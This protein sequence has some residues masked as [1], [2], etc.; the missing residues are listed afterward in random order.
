MVRKLSQLLSC[1][2]FP[3]LLWA[4]A[5]EPGG[6]EREALEELSESESE[7]ILAELTTSLPNYFPI[8][9][10]AG[11]AASYSPSGSI[12][13]RTAFHTSHGSNGRHCGHCHGP[14]SG[15]SVNPAEIQVAF[16]LT[17]GT[18]P[19]FNPLDANNPNADLSTFAKRA[20]GYSM[21]LKG[22]FRRGGVVR[23][24]AEYEI[25]AADDP[26]GFGS[27]ERFSV[28]RR[29]MPTSNLHLIN[30]IGW[31]DRTT[32]PGDTYAG[33]LAQARGNI[34]GGQQGQAPD[35]AIVQEIVDWELTI[36]HA[37]LSVPGVGR[38]DA[39]GARGGPRFVSEQARVAGRWDLFDA[40]IN[41]RP[42][43]CGT[44]AQDRKRAQIA[45]GQELFNE[46][47]SSTGGTCR[48]CHNVVNNGTN[49]NGVLFDIGASNANRRTPGLPLYTVRNKTT[50]EIRQTTDP[51]K[52]F[53][54]GRWADMNRF[55]SPTL[56]GVSSRAPYF[57]NGSAATLRDVIRHYEEERGFDFS[58]SEEADLLAFLN[59]L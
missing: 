59:A 10:S 1:L 58:P 8:P 52:A 36:A 38:L 49:L 56:R 20:K 57:H 13:L 32:V 39:C 6:G 23:A 27:T 4:C 7:L 35:P 3:A 11:V 46:A 42:G 14:E 34:T 37:Q 53:A 48:G 25:V 51:G 24:D 17:L 30:G 22:L 40:W 12:D 28:F 31:D 33:L 15:W 19:I 18:H 44:P 54:T 2:T 29:S 21:L 55:K 9:N 50:G 43:S 5:P 47:R 26:H 16:L 41:L 45:R